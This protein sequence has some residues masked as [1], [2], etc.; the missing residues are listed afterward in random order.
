[1]TTRTVL[2]P[3]LLAV[4]LL[5]VGAA[6]PAAASA[7][8]TGTISQACYSRVPQRGTQPIVVTLTGGTPNANYILSATDV[9]T[10]VACPQAS[11]TCRISCRRQATPSTQAQLSAPTVS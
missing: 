5:A 9:G 2:R 6:V 10:T 8:V 4:A 3:R 7:T 1:M 11:T